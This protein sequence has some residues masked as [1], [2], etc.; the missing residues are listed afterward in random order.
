MFTCHSCKDDF[1]WSE[2]RMW[3]CFCVFCVGCMK[4]AQS[5]FAAQ[6][7]VFSCATCHRYFDESCMVL[8]AGEPVTVPSTD[9]IST[10]LQ[11]FSEWSLELKE[12]QDNGTGVP[13]MY[14]QRGSYPDVVRHIVETMLSISDIEAIRELNELNEVVKKRWENAFMNLLKAPGKPGFQQA[15]TCLSR[16]LRPI[17]SI[18][19]EFEIIASQDDSYEIRF[20]SRMQTTWQSDTTGECLEI[21]TKGKTMRIE[22]LLPEST[23][24]WNVQITKEIVYT[25]ES[26]GKVIRCPLSGDKHRKVIY[27]NTC[28]VFSNNLLDANN[29]CWWYVITPEG[30]LMCTN[31]PSPST[32][33]TLTRYIH[34]TFIYFLGKNRIYRYTMTEAGVLVHVLKLPYVLDT[35]G[36]NFWM[37]ESY[38]LLIKDSTS[39][40][41]YK[42]I[43]D[44]GWVKEPNLNIKVTKF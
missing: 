35:H 3:T 32:V 39:T 15:M 14:E 5:E 21:R 44:D 16:M 22:S 1:D 2:G 7:K 4:D 24:K 29:N 13:A 28:Q 43:P 9:T 40:I 12:Q 37:T 8:E 17:Q 42:K 30:G 23:T 25:C 33:N 18:K 6:E 26:T 10:A 27:G 36:N 38:F 20:E 11:R 34:R 19:K 41:I 31:V